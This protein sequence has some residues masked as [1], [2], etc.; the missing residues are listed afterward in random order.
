MDSS[1]H[2]LPGVFRELS[3]LSDGD[4]TIYLRTDSHNFLEIHRT[5]IRNIFTSAVA[6][7]IPNVVIK[8]QTPLVLSIAA[9]VYVLSRHAAVTATDC[10]AT[11]SPSQQ[12]SPTLHTRSNLFI[13]ESLPNIVNFVKHHK[14]AFIVSAL[15]FL[16]LTVGALLTSYSRGRTLHWPFG[17]TKCSP[18]LLL[19]TRF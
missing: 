2:N 15:A 18:R 6:A 19:S 8:L 16:Y 17:R 12:G 7:F 10:S 14:A 3:R 4:H 5:G 9:A 11:C 1:S 13:V